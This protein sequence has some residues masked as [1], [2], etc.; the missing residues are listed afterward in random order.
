MGK[1]V[2]FLRL[3]NIKEYAY[4]EISSYQLVSVACF[5]S[6]REVLG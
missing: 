3:K 4:E 6:S 2:I 1:M 5:L